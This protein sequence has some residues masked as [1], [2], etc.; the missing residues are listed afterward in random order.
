MNPIKWLKSKKGSIAPGILQTAILGLVLLVVLFQLYAE[1]IP[2]A[3]DAGDALCNSG[4]PLGGLFEGTGV[5]F[6]IIMAALIILV[7]KAFLP[8]G[9]K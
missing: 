6:V 9:K 4:A 5:V 1:L 3:Q 2:T 7:V 8:G